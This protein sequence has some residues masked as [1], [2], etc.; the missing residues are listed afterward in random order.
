MAQYIDTQWEIVTYDVW[1]NDKDGYQVNDCYKG[2]TIDLRIKVATNN[3]DTDRE[4][5]SAYPSDYQIRQA[6]DCPRVQ[7][8]TTGDDTVIYVNRARD[9][10]PLGELRCISH[11]SLSPIS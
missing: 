5:K 9:S 8:D 7:I 6:L 11:S 3:P 4:F 1:G 10:Y 2:G